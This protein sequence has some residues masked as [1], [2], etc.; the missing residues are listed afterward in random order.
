MPEGRLPWE[1]GANPSAETENRSPKGGGHEK[2]GECLGIF[3]GPG[4]FNNAEQM[5]A[6][7]RTPEN[8]APGCR[9]SLSSSSDLPGSMPSTQGVHSPAHRRLSFVVQKQ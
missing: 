7:A 5:K 1:S 4:E 9:P 3:K 2:H 8:S 6:L